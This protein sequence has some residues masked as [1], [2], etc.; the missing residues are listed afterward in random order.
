M[1]KENT[2]YTV[3]KGSIKEVVIMSPA[4]RHPVA[5]DN[6]SARLHPFERFRL[7]NTMLVANFISNFVGVAI[8]MYMS[9]Q[10]G[11]VPFGFQEVHLIF[12]PLSFFMSLAIVLIY[13]Q[14]IRQYLELRFEGSPPPPALVLLSRRRVLNEPFFLIA[15]DSMIW[16]LAAAVYPVHYWRLGLG[17]EIVISTVFLSLQ[18]GVVTVTVAFFVSEFL[19]QRRLTPYFFPD[20]ALSSIPGTIRIRIGTRLIAFLAAT[21]VIPLGS[22]AR[23][24]WSIAHTIS[25]PLAALSVLQTTIFSGAVLFAAAGIWLTFLVRIN[26]TRSL[27]RMTDVLHKIR[28]GDFESRVMVTSNDEIGYVGDVVNEMAAGLKEREWIKETFGKYISPEIRDEVLAR[29]IPLDGEVREVTILFADLR[30]FTPLV[31]K[32]SPRQV[33]RIINRYFEEMEKA[34]RAHGGLIVQ[35]IGDEIEAVFGAPI[36]LSDHATQA[37]LAALGMNAGLKSVNRVL[38]EEGNSPLRHGIGIHTGKVVAANIGSP[39]RLSYALVGDT[40]NVAAR[41]QDVNKQHRTSIIVSA[42]TWQRLSQTLT[43]RR[44]PETTIKGKTRSMQIYGI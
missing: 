30:D 9:R 22:L 43:L 32:T 6:E 16:L 11:L 19:L 14:S 35:F 12:L 5:K 24:S 27:A 31:E 10:T 28:N 34:I 40:V 23:D 15:M 42:E 37:L 33:V 44:L 29:R 39:S 26:L 8:V 3:R 41:L 7:K 4:E 20:G 38:A 18:I 17:R 25:D 1:M 21:N 2:A 36:P 13:E